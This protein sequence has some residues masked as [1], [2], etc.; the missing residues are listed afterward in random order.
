MPENGVLLGFS[1][2]PSEEQDRTNPIR[3][4]HTKTIPYSSNAMTKIM[5]M[6]VHEVPIVERNSSMCRNHSLGVAGAGIG[7]GLRHRAGSKKAERSHQGRYTTS[8]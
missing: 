3:H 5:F 6:Y 8:H 7:S 2:R 1:L 4:A